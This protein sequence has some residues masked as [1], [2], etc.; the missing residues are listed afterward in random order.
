MKLLLVLLMAFCAQV[1][2][3][4]KYVPT[5]ACSAMAPGHQSNTASGPNP[6]GLALDNFNRGVVT[7]SNGMVRF[8]VSRIVKPFLRDL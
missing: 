2:C 8:T 5:G 7:L 4:S 1:H 6:Y 3:R